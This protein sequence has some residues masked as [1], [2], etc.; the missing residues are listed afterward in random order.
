[1]IHCNLASGRAWEPLAAHLGDVLSMAAVDM[2]G[3]G[4]S[5]MPLPDVDYQLQCAQA[6]IAV[7][8]ADNMG[9]QDLVGHS[10]GACVALRVIMLRPDLVRSLVLFEPVFF[11]FLH[12]VGSHTFEVITKNDRPFYAAIQ[13]GR[14]MD[15]TERFLVRWGM[16]GE[17]QKMAPAVRQGFAD[18]MWLIAAQRGSIIE[19]ND[20]RIRLGD[21]R[22]VACPTLVMHGG[23]SPSVMA[24]M[25]QVIC[26][27]IPGAVADSL[28]QAGHMLPITHA[29]ECAV[30]M[31]EFWHLN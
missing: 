14:T 21:L 3:Q 7:M 20:W 17:W 25:T 18:R 22:R 8:D 1:M 16:P 2:L 9:P 15:A 29:A 31:R 13:D 27:A 30:R 12:D 11:G 5:P 26:A 23:K 19:D 24:E 6:S 4:R 28:P 10:F